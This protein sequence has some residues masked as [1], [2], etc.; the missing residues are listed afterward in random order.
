MLVVL[1][2]LTGS[3]VPEEREYPTFEFI[4]PGS[5]DGMPGAQ[6]VGE[7]E[8]EESVVRSVVGQWSLVEWL[9]EPVSTLVSLELTSRSVTTLDEQRFEFR[10]WGTC[11]GV[12]GSYSVDAST[13]NFIPAPP[14]EPSPCFTALDPAEL[15][16][17]VLL[18]RADLWSVDGSLLTL[19]VTDAGG[20]VLERD[21]DSEQHG[22]GRT[23]TPEVH[24]TDERGF[25][26]RLAGEGTTPAPESGQVAYIAWSVGDKPS[27]A[28]QRWTAA[29]FRSRNAWRLERTLDLDYQLTRIYLPTGL[30]DSACVLAALNS[31]SGPRTATLRRPEHRGLHLYVQEDDSSGTASGHVTEVVGVVSGDCGGRTLGPEFG[32]AE[33]VGDSWATVGLTGQFAAPVVVVGPPTFRGSD[34]GVAEVRNVTPESFEIRFAEWGYHDGRHYWLEDIPYLVVESGSTTLP[35]GA[36]I[37][38]GTLTATGTYQDVS[39]GEAFEATPVVLTTV[40]R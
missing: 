29:R 8:Y 12:G 1:L 6:R 24:L 10:W 34:A 22:A 31:A 4:M 7:T 37:E 3:T 17:N 35:S 16:F 30:A 19:G 32:V 26:V 5:A 21:L 25:L 23:V 18:S 40:V 38:A 13:I 20:A 28:A 36:R 27:D 14:G 39:F 9:G 2:A 15:G 33:N 11:L